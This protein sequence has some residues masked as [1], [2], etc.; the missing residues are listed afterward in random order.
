[1]EKVMSTT[2]TEK[3]FVFMGPDEKLIQAVPGVLN[4]ITGGK[5]VLTDKKLFFSFISNISVDKQFIATYPYI[6]EANLKEGI[7]YSAITVS[8]KK[9]TFTISKMNKK[10]AK[11]L[12]SQLKT[13]AD[14]NK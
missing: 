11:K 3:F 9:D 13:I 14:K 5:L 12:Y 7:L 1:M 8:S 2:S 4:N 10:E 6:M